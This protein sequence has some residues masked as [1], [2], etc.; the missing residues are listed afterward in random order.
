MNFNYKKYRTHIL[1]HLANYKRNVL[2]VNKNGLDTRFK[3]EYPHIL[4]KNKEYL[5]IIHSKYGMDLWDLIKTYRIKLHKEF[6]HLNSSQ[7]L[8]FNLLY[9]IMK[10]NMFDLLLGNKEEIIGWKFEF[11]PNKKER[12]NF[13]AFIQTNKNDYYFELKFTESEFGSKE[14]ND[15]TILRYNE[16]YK[17]K[18][19]K[20]NITAELFLNNYQ[21]FRNLSYINTGIINFI[22]PKSRI[23]LNNKLCNVLKNYCN[24]E[25]RT[26]IN[27]LYIE[28]IVK[29]A[30]SVKKLN[31]YYKI[32]Y[33]KYLIGATST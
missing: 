6:H 20:F 29:K 28:E 14:I 17:E 13:D 5:N 1:E 23:D 3:K 22:I 19:K 7:A 12:T 33:E 16:I 10:E 18:M 24:L 32:F 15:K 31:E 9:P 27:I 4:P 11:E 30:I 8:C 26:R 2:K 21:I 25:L